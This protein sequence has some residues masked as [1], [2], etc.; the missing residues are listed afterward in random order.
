[1]KILALVMMC[2]FLLSAASADAQ[3]RYAVPDQIAD[4]WQI[5]GRA[6]QFIIVLPEQRMVAV[7]TGMNDSDLMFQPLD[8][9]QNYLLPAVKSCPKD[10]KPP[11]VAVNGGK[12]YA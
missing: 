11:A 5:A 4:G 10:S 3:Y 8:M 1:M 7:F 9:M 12:Q 6:G 2:G